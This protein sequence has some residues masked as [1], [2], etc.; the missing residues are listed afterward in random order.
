M[1]I[2]K[3]R[4]SLES[5]CP[6]LAG[7]AVCTWTEGWDVCTLFQCHQ[8]PASMV[9]VQVLRMDQGTAVQSTG[10]LGS[11]NPWLQS[12]DLQ[13]SYFPSLCLSFH[14]CKRVIISHYIDFS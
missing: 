9:P 14:I 3:M 5:H 6:L 1:R 2:M 8:L 11:Q 10:R 12:R 7:T 13:V 4:G